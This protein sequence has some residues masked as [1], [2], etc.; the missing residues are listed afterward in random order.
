MIASILINSKNI[1]NLEK[2]FDSYEENSFDINS[3][4]IIVNIDN[5]DKDIK[6][7]IEKQLRK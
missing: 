6:I 2:V 3:F 7:F 4:E 5:D 1:K